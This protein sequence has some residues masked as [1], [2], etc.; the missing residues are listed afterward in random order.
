MLK[1]IPFTH[2][3]AHEFSKRGF[4]G[5]RIVWMVARK[6]VNEKNGDLVVLPSG[7]PIIVDKTDW[8]ARS[9]YE[10]TYERPLISL[11]NMIKV[12]G[13][14]VDVGANIG[15]TL[16]NGMK[17]SKA[18]STYCAIEPSE[19]CQRGL[20]LSTQNIRNLGKIIKVALGDRN[21]T[22]VMHGLN[23]PQQSGGGSLL[24]NDGLKGV[25]VPVQVRTLD[26]LISEGEITQT[27]F[28]LKID[29]EGYEAQVLAGGKQLIAKQEICIFILEVSPSFASTEWVKQIHIKLSPNYTFFQLNEEGYIRK[30]PRLTKVSLEEALSIEDQW[31]LVVIRNDVFSTNPALNRFTG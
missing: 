21:E 12:D 30:K 23:N 11:L 18:N 16:W 7:F 1:K 14:F 27:V 10:G 19:Q 29:T 13:C 9:I 26:E 3:I 8:I 20:L 31:N 4:R 17:R 6:I 22:R 15:V 28:L 24:K 25:D 5:S 2:L